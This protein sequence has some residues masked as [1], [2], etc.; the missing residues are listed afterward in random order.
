[1]CNFLIKFFL[2]NKK[3]NKNECFNEILMIIKIYFFYND[4][5]D[6]INND[7]INI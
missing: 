6:I 1:M 5:M 2:S 3:L 4:L 7:L